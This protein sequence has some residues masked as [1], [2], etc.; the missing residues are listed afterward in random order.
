MR[1][2]YLGWMAV[3]AA[4]LC[5][6][7]S[8]GAQTLYRCGNQY[9]DTPCEAG[10]PGKRVSGGATRATTPDA[11]VDGDCSR[12]G[13]RALQIIWAREAGA[14]E[15]QQLAKAP[16]SGSEGGA[17]RRLIQAVYARRGSAPS[18]RAAI[19]SDCMAE[20]EKVRQAQAMSAA[21]A[22]LMQE[23]PAE[24]R[25]AAG[26]SPQAETPRVAAAQPSA[27]GASGTSQ[28][29]EEMRQRE[30]SRLRNELAGVRDQQRRGGSASTMESLGDQ[31]RTL[32]RSL[33]SGG[34]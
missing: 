18:I 30:C 10:K 6:A 33:G 31:R 11:A 25:G 16:P 12:R 3:V 5:V 26:Q 14:T 13:E 2:S 32:E 34:C 27:E 19:E 24:E 15:E 29:A 28:A 7:G 23:L 8:I 22:K 4:V 17:H 1:S 21:A 9:Q 20:K